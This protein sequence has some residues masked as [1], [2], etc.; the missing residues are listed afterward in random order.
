MAAVNAVQ[1]RRQVERHS[2]TYLTE[3]APDGLLEFEPPASPR[4]TFP[5]ML[6]VTL[7][8]IVLVSTASAILLLVRA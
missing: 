4:Q 3:I 1:E 6:I 8:I 7:A 2:V 5:T